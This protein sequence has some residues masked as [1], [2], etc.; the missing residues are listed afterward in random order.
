MV[1]AGTP[2]FEITDLANTHVK[3]FISEKNWPGASGAG[4][5]D[6]GGCFSR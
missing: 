2:V 3:V 5:G 6:Q 1:N 4:S